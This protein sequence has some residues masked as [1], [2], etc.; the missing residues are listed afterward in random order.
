M[1]DF[2]TALISRCVRLQNRRSIEL[3]AALANSWWGGRAGGTRCA[4]HSIGASEFCA[5]TSLDQPAPCFV[6]RAERSDRLT[7]P[8]KLGNVSNGQGGD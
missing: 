8:P 2:G 7:S 1:R 3:Y 4:V 6:G 5:E